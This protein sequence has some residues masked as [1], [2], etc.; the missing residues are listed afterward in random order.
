M[1]LRWRRCYPAGWLAGRARGLLEAFDMSWKKSFDRR[2][3]HDGKI[4]RVGHAT[5]HRLMGRD[6]RLLM[7]ERLA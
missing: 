2:L 5:L 1:P 4:R 6:H 3:S 7:Y